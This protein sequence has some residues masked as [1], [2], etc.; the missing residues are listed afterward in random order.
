MAKVFDKN[1]IVIIKKRKKTS[2]GGGDIK[3]SSMNKHKRRNKGMNLK[4]G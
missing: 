4:R 1:K 3:T 2:Q